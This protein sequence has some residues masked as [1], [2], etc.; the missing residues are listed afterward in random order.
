MIYLSSMKKR[1]YSQ[2]FCV[3]AAIIE[4]SN[5]FL[6]VKEAKTETGE[7]GQWNHPAG[8]IEVGEDPI[9]AIRREVKEEIGY[10]FEPT[11]VLG[12]YSLV[13]KDVIPTMHPI[14]IIFTGEITGEQDALADDV[15][16]MKWFT[17]EEIEAMDNATLRDMDIKSMIDDY[18]E[19][20]RYPL[21]ILEHTVTEE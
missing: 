12:V 5:K 10:D 21:G 9:D 3:V 13:K 16:E 18:L 11:H 19:I 17:P 15:S 6:L 4:R 20:E 2:T 1:A 7:D 14:K 8:W